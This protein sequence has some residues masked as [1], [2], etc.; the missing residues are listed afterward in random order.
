[1]KV[2]DDCIKGYSGVNNAIW[3]YNGFEYRILIKTD[4]KL[5]KQ[6]LKAVTY[7]NMH[8]IAATHNK[9]LRPLLCRT[10]NKFKVKIEK[11]QV[12]IKTETKPRIGFLIKIRLKQSQN[13]SN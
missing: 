10:R 4:E 9:K 8:I 2:Q 1:M 6:C 13:I 5:E 7:I 12:K 11:E 3:F